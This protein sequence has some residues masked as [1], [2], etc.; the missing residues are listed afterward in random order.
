MLCIGIP[1]LS[2]EMYDKQLEQLRQLDP[3]TIRNLLLLSEKIKIFY[4]SLDRKLGNK[5]YAKYVFYIAIAV[6][7]IILGFTTWKVVT[8]IVG[9]FFGSNSAAE[10]SSQDAMSENTVLAEGNA[11]SEFEF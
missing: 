9:I 3:A 6:I 5:G 7:I 4:D 8:F 11:E 1:V 2:D 10:I